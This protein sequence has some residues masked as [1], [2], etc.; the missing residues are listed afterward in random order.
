MYTS[1][2]IC[3]SLFYAKF[4]DEV[5]S[6]FLCELTDPCEIEAFLIKGSDFDLWNTFV[7][8]AKALN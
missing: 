6:V 7:V 3:C 4:S 8:V 2:I 5:V 1:Y